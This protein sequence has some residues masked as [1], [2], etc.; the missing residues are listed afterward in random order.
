MERVA[1]VISLN[2]IDPA[3]I[4]Y[5]IKSTLDLLLNMLDIMYDNK[6]EDDFFP[7]LSSSKLQNEIYSRGIASD[8]KIIEGM[9]VQLRKR[10]FQMDKKRNILGTP[11]S[12][13]LFHFQYDTSLF[14]EI[15]YLGYRRYKIVQVIESLIYEELGRKTYSEISKKMVEDYISSKGITD[16]PKNFQSDIT[17]IFSDLKLIRFFEKGNEG[18]ITITRRIP[19]PIA[20][21]LACYYTPQHLQSPES[22]LKAN[23]EAIDLVAKVLF[24]S[25]GDI[26]DILKQLAEEGVI[27]Y[28]QKASLNQFLLPRNE[29]EL[30]SAIIKREL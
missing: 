6:D 24:A 23:S 20:T 14:Q 3:R 9:V 28:E 15:L 25:K 5:S 30:I 19:N 27:I 18:G 7:L 8:D 2:E 16:L 26:L 4:Q 1:R 22:P 13:I 21:L 12:Y 10:Y 11:L 17:T 29:H